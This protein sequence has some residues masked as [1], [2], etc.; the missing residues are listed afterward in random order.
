MDI[1]IKCISSTIFVL[2]SNPPGHFR[3]HGW[4]CRCSP[5]SVCILGCRRC[6]WMWEWTAGL[7][8]HPEQMKKRTTESSNIKQGKACFQFNEAGLPQQ[9]VAVVISHLIYWHRPNKYR[10]TWP[11]YEPITTINSNYS[12][13]IIAF[14]SYPRFII[15]TNI[16]VVC[17]FLLTFFY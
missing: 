6:T 10:Q 15:T 13:G 17:F 1:T 4:W 3:E 8:F 7:C 11:V 9:A 16:W 12:T 5:R 14:F 2:P